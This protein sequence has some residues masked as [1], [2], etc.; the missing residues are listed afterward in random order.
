MSAATLR[1]SFCIHTL[2]TAHAAQQ[3]VLHHLKYHNPLKL[4]SD[5]VRGHVVLSMHPAVKH[6][7]SPQVDMAVVQDEDEATAGHTTVRCLM[8]PAPQVWTLFMFFYGLGGFLVLIGLMIASTQYSLGYDLWGLYVALG[9]LLLGGA[10][11]AV[12]RSGQRLAR[13]EM[14]L[15]K[16]Y[17]Q[18]LPW[19]ESPKTEG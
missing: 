8:G 10:M 13:E 1:P 3:L 9:G 2:L 15:M 6:F 18:S 12:A 4:Q 17:I 16:S 14:R 11:Y 7:W 19:Q 5:M